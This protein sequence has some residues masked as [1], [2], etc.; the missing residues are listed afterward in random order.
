MLKKRTAGSLETDMYITE[1]YVNHEQTTLE[2]YNEGKDRY[3]LLET[4][5]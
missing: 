5:R 3:V 1:Y 2:H 4:I